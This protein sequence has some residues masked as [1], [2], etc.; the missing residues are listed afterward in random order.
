MNAQFVLDHSIVEVVGVSSI[1]SQLVTNQIF[2]P[3][4]AILKTSL[5]EIVIRGHS[6]SV[7][8][9]LWLSAKVLLLILWKVIHGSLLFVQ[10]AEVLVV[11][12][13]LVV[14]KGVHPLVSTIDGL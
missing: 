10:S 1:G 5:L 4:L 6:I 11:I 9:N 2:R 3:S 13:I 8:E 12:R 14:I 7:T